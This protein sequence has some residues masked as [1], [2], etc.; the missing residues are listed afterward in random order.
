MHPLLRWGSRLVEDATG[1]SI[2]KTACYTS[3]HFMGIYV[4]LAISKA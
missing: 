2:P 3:D 4:Q 1:V